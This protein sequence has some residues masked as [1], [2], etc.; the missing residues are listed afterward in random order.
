LRQ[1]HKQ[2]RRPHRRQI[3]APGAG[4]EGDRRGKKL[5]LVWASPVHFRTQRPCKTRI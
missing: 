3:A 4:K 2:D 5:Q 1:D